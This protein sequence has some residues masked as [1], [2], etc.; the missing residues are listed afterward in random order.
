MSGVQI[1]VPERYVEQALT[2]IMEQNPKVCD[3]LLLF[4]VQE[5]ASSS[6]TFCNAIKEIAKTNTNDMTSNNNDAS[7]ANNG[8][9]NCTNGKNKATEGVSALQQVISAAHERISQRAVDKAQ[10]TA[11]ETVATAGETQ[12]TDGKN[13]ANDGDSKATAGETQATDGKNKANDGETVAT[14]GESEDDDML[15]L[16]HLRSRSNLQRR[17]A[18]SGSDSDNDGSDSDNGGSGS[19]E[20][21]T[22]NADGS[23]S[24]MD[25]NTS[26]MDGSGSNEGSTSNADGSK[27][28]MDGSDNDSDDSDNDS[29]DNGSDNDSDDNGSAGDGSDSA[30]DGS[31]SDSDSDGDGSDSAGDGSDSDSDGDGSDSAGDGSDSDS[32]GDGSD[33]NAGAKGRDGSAA[34]AIGKGRPALFEYEKAAVLKALMSQQTAT[35]VRRGKVKENL[36]K[37]GIDR[38]DLPLFVAKMFLLIT[39]DESFGAYEPE[40]VYG[41]LE[42]LE[43][44]IYNEPGLPSL[45]SL[46]EIAVNEPKKL[47]SVVAGATDGRESIMGFLND[48]NIACLFEEA[49]CKNPTTLRILRQAA[50]VV[51]YKKKDH[52][53]FLKVQSWSLPEFKH[54]FETKEWPLKT[55]HKTFQH[56]VTCLMRKAVCVVF[57][58]S[59]CGNP[60]E[61][62]KDDR[63][64]KYVTSKT[65]RVKR[66]KGKGKRKRSTD[67]DDRCKK[68]KRS[69]K[70]D[71]P[72]EKRKRSSDESEPCKQRKL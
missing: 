53:A 56:A 17:V 36:A 38:E 22:S 28:S 49:F 14:D 64:Q 12:A 18:D 62:F 31:D 67:R 48:P 63:V 58:V 41:I 7:N 70:R 34:N 68:R 11:G 44:F 10:A 54:L 47:H 8:K 46:Y 55:C 26:S 61:F 35:I 57:E 5:R 30:G 71:D 24:S 60:H 66:R 4:L 59:D 2:Q 13:K 45:Q 27:S 20:G 42:Q 19:N 25:G 72:C 40:Q 37:L 69:T 16:S 33:A 21:S 51:F 3:R 23:K 50:A 29:D 1:T 52:D 32:D 15:T 39:L 6:A 9:S 43:A 65:E